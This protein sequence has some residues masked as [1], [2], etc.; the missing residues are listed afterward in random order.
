MAFT[1]VSLLSALAFLASLAN[2][3]AFHV[4]V[5]MMVCNSGQKHVPHK[6]M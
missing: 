4:N 1:L 5:G 2:S 6:S 3:H